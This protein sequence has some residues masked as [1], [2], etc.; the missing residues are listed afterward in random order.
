MVAGLGIA[1]GMV[2]AGM[3]GEPQA[4]S[5]SPEQP[6]VVAG[7]NHVEPD[8]SPQDHPEGRSFA[9][10]DKK[11]KEGDGEKDKADSKYSSFEEAMTAGVAYLNLKEYSKSR[12]PFEAALKLAP[13]DTARVR[14]HRA[15][16]PA[17]RQESDWQLGAGALEFIIAHSDQDAERSLARTELMGFLHARGK[18]DD[19]IKRYEGRLKKSNDEA[20]LY[21]LIEIYSRLKSDAQRASVLLEQWDALKR[22]SGQEMKVVDAAKLAGEYVKQKKFQ[23]G[24]ELF[25]KTAPRDAKLAAWHFKEAAAA[26]VKAGNKERAIAAAKAAEEAEPEKRGELLEHFW[27][28]GLADVF[29]DC[30]EYGRS[31]PHYEQAIAKTMIAGYVKDCQ[32]RLAQAKAK[33]EKKEQ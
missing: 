10:L 21:I 25:E 30:G 18:T 3:N 16:L 13:D 28:R 9:L 23:Q 12:E 6:Q 14:I 7:V 31:I 20:A 4:P 8:A 33:V 22:K 5:H 17:Y 11:S 1:I 15:L 24:A 26:W 29:F 19:A 2:L 32:V 27:H